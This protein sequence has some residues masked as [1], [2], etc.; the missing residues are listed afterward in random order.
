MDENKKTVLEGY[1]KE[2]KNLEEMVEWY[3]N[4]S[5]QS[6]IKLVIIKMNIESLKGLENE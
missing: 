5:E 1:E 4:Q 2:E 3:K 6:K